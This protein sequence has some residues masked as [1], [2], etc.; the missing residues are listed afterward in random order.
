MIPTKQPNNPLH[1]MT[2]EMIVTKLVEEY[3][4]AGLG[5]RIPI[6]CFNENPS[7]KSSLKFLRQTPLGTE[8]G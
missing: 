7:I 1:G 6:R 5:K 3:G 4:W 2:L 8:K